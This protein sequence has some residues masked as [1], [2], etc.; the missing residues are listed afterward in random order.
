MKNINKNKW[1]KISKK[2]YYPKNPNFIKL[3]NFDLNLIKNYKLKKNYPGSRI[4]LHASTKDKIQQM[5]LFHPKGSYIR[6]HKSISNE[7]SYMILSGEMDLILFDNFG[8]IKKKIEL[9]DLKSKKN[10]FFRMKK[11]LFRTMIVKKDTFFLEVK[12]GPFL[13]NKSTMYADWSPKI[14]D[15]KKL[16]MFFLNVRKFK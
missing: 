4:C 8:K 14:H 9:G 13:K 15:K 12:Q 7:E 16:E 2:E 3:N 5:I 11:S 10:F 1:I 6:P